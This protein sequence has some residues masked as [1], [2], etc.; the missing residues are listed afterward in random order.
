LTKPEVLA[1]SNRLT[2]LGSGNLPIPKGVD[3]LKARPQR[4][5]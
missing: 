5:R 1:V 2:S 3:P 4:G